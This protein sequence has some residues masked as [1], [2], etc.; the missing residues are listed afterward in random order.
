VTVAGD[1]LEHTGVVVHDGKITDILKQDRIAELYIADGSMALED[2]VL[3]PC[4]CSAATNSA[5]S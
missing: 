5:P 4:T 2:H 1:G 3:M